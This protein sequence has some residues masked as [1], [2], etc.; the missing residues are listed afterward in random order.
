MAEEKRLSIEEASLSG[1]TGHIEKTHTDS[2]AATVP[3][4]ERRVP[5]DDDEYEVTA[6]TWVVVSVLA[7]SYAISFFVVPTVSY[8]QSTI[9]TQLGSPQDATWFIS[10]IE[11][12]VATS[13]MIC[14]ANSDL[15]GR[16]YFII[17]GN[18]LLFIGFLIAGTAK[19]T[20]QLIAGMCFI[21]FGG[22]N[23]QLAAFALPELLP[24]KWRHIAVTIAD[25][26]IVFCVTV[27]PVV[28]RF[29]V[30]PAG[31]YSWRWLFYGPAIAVAVSFALLVWLYH[32]PKHPRGVP[33][34]VAIKELD[35]LGAIL[36]TSALTLILT[37]VVY[38]TYEKSN[39]AKV[40][41]PLVVG[42]V[43]MILFA[44]WERYGNLKQPLTPTHIFTAKNGR[45]FTAPFI[46][47][48]CVC[49][50]Y[51]GS[52]V[53]WPIMIDEIFTTETTNFRY[54]LLL[55]LPQS[56][57]Y[58][59]GA[60]LLVT[61]GTRIGNAIGW[62]WEY[63]GVVSWMSFWGAMLAYSNTP[64][65][66]SSAM[67]FIFL[68]LM[69]YGWAQYLSIAYIQFGADQKELG[70]AGGLAGVARNAGG[71]IAVG[72]YSTVLKN[73]Q[74]SRAA[75]LVPKV[76]IAAGLPSS[77]VP[78]VLKALPLGSKALQ[79]VP[80]MN[81]KI[82]AAVGI[83]WRESYGWGLRATAF[84]SIA[85]GVICI[86]SALCC[87][88]IRPKMNNRIEIFLENDTHADMNEFH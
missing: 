39:N 6:K 11:I 28:G 59:L 81:S 74:G 3:E 52:N 79:A 86:V 75:S 65:R 4:S 54:A 37:G 43:L 8:V 88:E 2:K 82:A 61:F 19:G 40:V 78:A 10:V 38:S 83:A 42:F 68:S 64:E 25:A 32:P 29:S 30:E 69:G 87:V 50:F 49:M 5:S 76:A 53:V 18:V 47:G 15:F 46:S 31:S 67:A 66:K 56:L 80:G 71:A 45:D 48:L 85:F 16:R 20:K 34:H 26:G 12:T 36:F 84:T 33:W 73:T 22:G 17:A 23:C 13:F 57:G 14:G 27:G 41:A 35:Y 62:K 9:A 77:S 24:N 63:V 21:G 1:S 51:F 7:L 60:F 58:V 44:L 72:V 70:I 55:T